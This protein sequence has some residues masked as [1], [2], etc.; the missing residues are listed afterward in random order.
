[1]KIHILEAK[2]ICWFIVSLSNVMRS[3]TVAFMYLK[4]SSWCEIVP[5][6]NRTSGRTSDAM[7]DTQMTDE[8]VLGTPLVDR[9]TVLANELQEK[10]RVKT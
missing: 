6:A 7:I 8:I 1:M 9:T 4:A 10:E 2:V 5:F 3:F